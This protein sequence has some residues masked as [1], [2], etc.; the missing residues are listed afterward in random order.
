MHSLKVSIREQR[1]SAKNLSWKKLFYDLR[2]TRL[3]EKTVTKN[4]N[5]ESITY[6]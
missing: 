1:F 3:V 5:E 4:L 6:F 2:E